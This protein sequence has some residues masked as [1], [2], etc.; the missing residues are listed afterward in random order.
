MSDSNRK[1]TDV[2]LSIES[3][4]EALLNHH[5]SQDLN[6]KILSNKFNSLV[7]NIPKIISE[8]KEKSVV[9]ATPKITVEAVDTYSGSG[10]IKTNSQFNL[11]QTFEPSGAKKF[12]RPDIIEVRDDFREHSPQQL[13]NAPTKDRSE[14]SKPKEI[15]LISNP[16]NAPIVQ[17]SQRIVDKNQK[18]VFLAEVEV[19]SLDGEVIH[20]TRT[21]S[22]GKWSGTL[23]S[24]K[25]RV[26]VS[27]K[28]SSMKQK[29]D[30]SQDIELNSDKTMNVLPDLIVK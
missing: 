9:H 20:R 2:L 5:K 27:K 11:E 25:Y 3:K 13:N 4:L 21:N 29:V 30:V 6:L 22:V 28:E 26:S 12:S 24:G 1:A 17:V 10:L 15:N 7:E 18:S 23:K 19:K 16:E 8:I 14:G